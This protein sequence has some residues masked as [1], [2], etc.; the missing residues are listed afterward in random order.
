MKVIKNYLYNVGY[1]L[2]SMMVPIITVPYISRTLGPYCSGINSYTNSWVTFFYLFGQMGITLYG[3]RQIAY[4]YGDLKKRSKSFWEIEALQIFTSSFALVAYLIT[5]LFFIKKYQLFFLLQALWIVATGLDISWYFMGLEDFK[6]TVTRNVLVKIV[7]LILIFTV[8]HTSKDLW[9]YILLLGIAQL[10]GALSLWP[11]LKR[12]VVWVKFKYWRPFKH[13]YP[14]LLLFIPTITT[15]VYLVVNRIMLGAMESQ[16]AVGE[17]DYAD[18]LIKMVLAVVTSLGTV[19]L[20]HV[21]SQFAKGDMDSV[22][23]SLYSSFSFINF[24]TIPLMFGVMAISNKFAPWF[25]GNQYS[26]TGIIMFVEAPAILFIAWSSTTGNQY[27]MP[28][29]KIQAFTLS[30]TVGAITNILAN[31]ILIKFAGG[32]GAALATVFSEITTATIQLVYIKNQIHLLKLFTGM[33]KYVVSSLIMFFIVHYMTDVLKMTA[34]TL[35]IE[36]VIAILLYLGL[37]I[38]LRAPIIKEAEI[39]LKIKDKRRKK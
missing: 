35:I 6:K 4:F 26:T 1:Q 16:A 15:Q 24:L 7:T 27:L 12:S 31:L 2:L 14:A 17:F 10:G 8:V 30:V 23:K 5:I 39:F 22:N 3:N 21:A 28:I 32:V 20:P 38:L 9:K 29:N 36:V 25:L 19:M 34:L 18:K 33:W 37:L 11:Y 13:F